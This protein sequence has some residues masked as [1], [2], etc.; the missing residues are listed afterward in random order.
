MAER[1]QFP[2]GKQEFANI[3]NSDIVY[4]DKTRLVYDLTC[5]SGRYFF[6]PHR[7]GKSLLLSTM[8]YYF[9]GRQ[10]LFKGLASVES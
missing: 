5:K 2:I 4:I 3:H 7:F 8:R 10:D 6:H 1:R 9:E